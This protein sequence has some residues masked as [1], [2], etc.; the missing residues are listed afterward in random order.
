MISTRTGLRAARLATVL[1]VAALVVAG[2]LWWIFSGDGSKRITALFPR[3]VGVYSGSDVR[4]LGVRI[5]QVE[6]VTPVG[7]HVEVTLSVDGQAPVS[8]AT[9]ALVVAPSVVSDRYV[10]FSTVARKGDPRLTDGTVIGVERTGTPVEL[11]ELYASLNDLATSLGPKGA[12]SDGA[13]SELLE[14]GAANLDGNGRAINENIRNFADL[15]RTLSDSKDDLFGTLDELGKFTDMLAANDNDVETV[16]QQLAQ[17]WQTLSADREELSGA[18]T[19]LGSALGEVQAF[20]RD[21]RAAI[22]SNVDKLSQ[23]TQVL[24]DQRAQLAETLDTLPLA[25]S[26]VLGA[27][28]PDSGTLQGRTYLDEFLN[29]RKVSVPPGMEPLPDGAPMPDSAP[30]LPLPVSGPVYVPG[31]AG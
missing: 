24:V 18:L 14:T 29:P 9:K 6:T 17:V 13:L 2:G 28:D 15:A 5:G 19:A 21:N 20:I 4:L 12:N 22:K 27:F 26:N 8:A 11:D 1:I 3:A 31:G 16:N 7:E 23:T 10:Q 30:D 25:A